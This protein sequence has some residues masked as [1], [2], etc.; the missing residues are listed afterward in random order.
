M[1]AGACEGVSS[2]VSSDVT[3]TVGHSSTCRSWQSCEGGFVCG[4]PSLQWGAEASLKGRWPNILSNQEY[5]SNSQGEQ[6]AYFFTL[7]FKN[8]IS[9]CSYGFMLDDSFGSPSYIW[10]SSILIFILL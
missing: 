7:T 3:L 9:S 1:G 5:F 10:I 8:C 6:Q 4:W 2:D